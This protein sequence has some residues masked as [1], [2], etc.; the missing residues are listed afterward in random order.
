MMT[1]TAR[2]PTHALAARALTAV[3]LP[4]LVGAL[5]LGAAAP[6][7][8]QASTE[9]AFKATTFSLSAYG[10]TR[11]APDMAT[12]NLGGP[13]RRADRRRGPEGQRRP[14]EPGRWPR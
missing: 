6:A 3:G 11:V 8:A 5:L 13:D 4:A 1:N 7:M 2:R 9:A 12:I 14:D 10:E